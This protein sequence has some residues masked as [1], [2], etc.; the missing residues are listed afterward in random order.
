MSSH[1][2]MMRAVSL[3]SVML[4]LMVLNVQVD[5]QTG[6]QCPEAFWA[7]GDSL[8]DTGNAFAAFPG[9]P[10]LV[11]NYPYGES[12]TFRDKPGHNRFCDGRLVID[13]IGTSLICLNQF[14][15]AYVG[16]TI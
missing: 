9:T 13:F 10:A 12:Y 1:N 4:Q 3:L 8:S 6:F 7:F 16:T 2:L 15:E 11:L 5:G 14:L